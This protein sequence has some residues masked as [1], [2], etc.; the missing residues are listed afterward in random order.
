M[1][2][3]VIA[4]LSAQKTSAPAGLKEYYVAFEELYDKKLWHQLTVKLEQFTTQPAAPPHLIAIYQNF[5]SDW[6]KKMNRIS[7]VKFATR[8]SKQLKDPKESLAFLTPFVAKLKG[9]K[10]ALDAFVLVSMEVTHFKLLTGKIEECKA[11]IDECEKILEKLLS[12]DPLI[13]A[14]YYRVAADYHKATLGYP[15]YYHNALLFLSSVS[16]DELSAQ[17]KQERAFDLSMSALLGEGLY[18]FGELLMHPIL[19]SLQTSPFAWLRQLLFFYN[20]GD[21]EGF[22]KISKTGDFLKQ[23]L[24]VA[25]IGFLRQK[26]CLMTLMEAVFK[27]SKSERGKMTFS[28]IARDT[29]VPME[30]VEHLVMKALS[31][32]LIK[33]CIDEVDGVVLV[34]WRKLIVGVLGPAPCLGQETNCWNFG[35]YPGL[36]AKGPSAG[37]Q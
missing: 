31:L 2:A 22:E 1:S 21:M 3:S 8:A 32:G 13:N 30:E 25:A 33:G 36:D 35:A 26:L 23:P 18:N 4:W 15:Q 5:V 28:E 24:L 29:R 34:R 27:R 7:L 19:D 11:D 14:S 20:S 6:E 10:N 9:D 37:P 17:E 12:Q 16:L